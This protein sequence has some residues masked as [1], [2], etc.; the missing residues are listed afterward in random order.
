MAIRGKNVAERTGSDPPSTAGHTAASLRLRDRPRVKRE[1]RQGGASPG[2]SSPERALWA[3]ILSD[4]VAI[5]LGRTSASVGEADA[6][7]SW[8]QAGSSAFSGFAW[9]CDLLGLDDA[10]IRER[11]TH[12]MWRLTPARR[13]S[14]AACSAERVAA[15]HVPCGPSATVFGQEVLKKKRRID[16]APRR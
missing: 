14:L 4:A 9:C 8:I 10:A 2:I 12:G 16:P 5:C 6:A 15:A 1:C 11:V 3:A 13:R 7:L